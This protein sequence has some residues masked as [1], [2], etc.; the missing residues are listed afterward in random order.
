MYFGSLKITIYSIIGYLIFISNKSFS[1]NRHLY[2]VYRQKADSL[3]IYTAFTKT[4]QD[5]KIQNEVSA[6]IAKT[7]F[8]PVETGYIKQSS[9]GN[10][11]IENFVT[12]IHK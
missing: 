4:V 7:I 2:N 6:L 12:G 5:E 3:K 10:S 8:E 1:N 11:I 9:E